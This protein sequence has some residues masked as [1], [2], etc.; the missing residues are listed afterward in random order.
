ML[1]SAV[2]Y[3]EEQDYERIAGLFTSLSLSE[4]AG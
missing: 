3:D 4:G 1:N 2:Y